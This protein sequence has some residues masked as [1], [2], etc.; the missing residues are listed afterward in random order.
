MPLFVSQSVSQFAQC[1]SIRS[2][3]RLDGLN[4][5]SIDPAVDANYVYFDAM[6]E[7]SLGNPGPCYLSPT[8]G[9]LGREKTKKGKRSP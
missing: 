8:V 1:L 6:Y 9:T 2:R 4:G 5:A 7:A 3:L